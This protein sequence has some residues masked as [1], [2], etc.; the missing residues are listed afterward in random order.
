[1][2]ID[3]AMN[4]DVAIDVDRSGT[5]MW[6]FLSIGCPLEGFRAPLKGFWG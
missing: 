3:I 2:H 1:M 4:I 5:D 6:L